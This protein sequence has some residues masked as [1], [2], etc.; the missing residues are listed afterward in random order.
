MI[1]WET[2]QAGIK[3]LVAN[4]TGLTTVQW[5]DEQL[6][7][8]AAQS[9]QFAIARC[10][11]FAVT[12]IG[13]WDDRQFATGTWTAGVFEAEDPE[14]DNDGALFETIRGQRAFTLR[15]S[16]ESYD[17]RPG[18]TARQYLEAMRDRLTRKSIQP[19]LNLLALGFAEVLMLRD[20]SDNQDD[21]VVS[22]AVFDTRWNLGTSDTDPS[23]DEPGTTTSPTGYS[24]IST[25]EDP[26]WET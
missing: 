20:I 7:L 18:R 16:V 12:S 6:P 26:E 21:H 1:D 11:V 9:N 13:A 4:L 22:K 10:M 15:V 2:L 5:Y 19:T 17:Q 23:G 3:T 24:R 8:V 25:I 14:D